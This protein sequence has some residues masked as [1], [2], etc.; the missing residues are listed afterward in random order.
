MPR[1]PTHAERQRAERETAYR[2]LQANNRCM[3]HA[4]CTKPS[5]LQCAEC[6]LWF[7][8]L[9]WLDG[10]VTHDGFGSELQWWCAGCGR[11]PGA[12]MPAHLLVPCE[13]KYLAPTASGG[14]VSCL[15]NARIEELE[16]HKVHVHTGSMVYAFIPRGTTCCKC[17]SQL[18][19]YAFYHDWRF[20]CNP[21]CGQPTLRLPAPAARVK[22]ANRR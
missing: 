8:D 5:H 20:S 9:E 16:R 2:R 12:G 4:A 11:R 10:V 18:P 14:T 13:P 7:H 15:P 22:K 1:S 21:R 19:E 6:K 17:K 3:A